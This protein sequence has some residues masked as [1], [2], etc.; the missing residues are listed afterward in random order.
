[1]ALSLAGV[2]KLWE[3]NGEVRSH[4]RSSGRLFKGPQPGEVEP[5]CVVATAALNKHALMPLVQ[6]VGQTPSKKI[7][8]IGMVEAEFLGK[9]TGGSGEFIYTG[10]LIFASMLFQCLVFHLPL[11][12]IQA[13]LKQ[14]H[15]LVFPNITVPKNALKKDAWI[16]KSFVVLVKRKITRAAQSRSDDFNELMRALH[17]DCPNPFNDWN[18]YSWG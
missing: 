17:P 18:P 16:A 11:D 8:S 3:S 6:R 4:F 5:S 2:H 14:L 15:G 7:F 1:M 13:R 10:Y 9:A 12:N